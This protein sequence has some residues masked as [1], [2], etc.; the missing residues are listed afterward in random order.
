MNQE[1]LMQLH[2]KKRGFGAKGMQATQSLLKGNA[3]TVGKNINQDDAQ[4]MV[5]GVTTVVRSTTLRQSAE[6]ARPAQSMQLRKKTFMSNNLAS[7]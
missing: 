1:T 3:S 4:C 6:G 2:I 7:K 5:K